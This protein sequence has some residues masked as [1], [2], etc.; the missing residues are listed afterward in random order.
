MRSSITKRRLHQF[1]KKNLNVRTH[2]I[3]CHLLNKD[4]DDS[5]VF[6]CFWLAIKFEEEQLEWRLKDVAV[7]AGLEIPFVYQSFKKAEWAILLRNDND[8][9]LPFRN[10]V[11]TILNILNKDKYDSWIHDILSTG[12]LPWMGAKEWA[13]LLRL[14]HFVLHPI[15]QYVRFLSCRRTTKALKHDQVV[16]YL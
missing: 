6:A 7:A 10:K 5:K 2:S 12:M 15:L 14:S 3:A 4:D 1:A 13:R 9:T 8:Y 11:D 16:F